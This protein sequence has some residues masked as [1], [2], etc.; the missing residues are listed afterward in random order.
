MAKNSPDGSREDLSKIADEELVKWGKGELVKRLRKTEAERVSLMLE[1]GN[2]IKD[3]NRRLQLHLHE[4][5][6][7]KDINQRLQDD[8]QELRELCC[9]LDD[10]R[11]KGKKLSREWQRFG[12]FTASAVWKEVAAHQHKLRELEARQEALLREN[13]ELKEIALMLDEERTEAGSRSSIDSLSNLN[14]GTGTRDVGDGSSTSSTGSA[15]SP[16]HHHPKAGDKGA[17]SKRSTDDLSAPPPHHH[18]HRSIPNGLN[19]RVRTPVCSS[20]VCR[21]NTSCMNGP[22]CLASINESTMRLHNP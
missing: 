3:V 8:N 12:R 20:G 14:G 11:Q 13:L 2:L 6:G 7:L 16:D 18:H 1:H 15:G 10:D 22:M 5:R 17:P 21:L 9:F 19:E 4:I